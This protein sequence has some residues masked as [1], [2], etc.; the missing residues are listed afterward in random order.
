L[1]AVVVLPL[2]FLGQIVW[3][4]V[5]AAV[6]ARSLGALRAGVLVGQVG[7]ATMGPPRLHLEWPPRLPTWRAPDLGVARH[8][9]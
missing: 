7:H 6:V 9:A 8:P 5:V 2:V 3:R 4:W 1:L